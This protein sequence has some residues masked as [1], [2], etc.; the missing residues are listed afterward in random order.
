MT[1]QQ[2]AAAEN[3]FLMERFEMRL[4]FDEREA[5]AEQLLA[6]RLTLHAALLDEPNAAETPTLARAA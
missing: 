2:Q 1:N 4:R 6:E 3:L 5:E